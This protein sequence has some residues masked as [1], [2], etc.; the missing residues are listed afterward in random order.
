MESVVSFM[1]QVSSSEVWLEK[2]WHGHVLMVSIQE[3]LI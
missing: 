1:T 2:K 3:K